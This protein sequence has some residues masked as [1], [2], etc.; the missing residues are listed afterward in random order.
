MRYYENHADDV[1]LSKNSIFDDV[2]N[3]Q[4]RWPVA[5]MQR[6]LWP[7]LCLK[8]ITALFTT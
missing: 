4:Y 2:R 8:L 1:V 6:F 7:Y 5:V 3:D